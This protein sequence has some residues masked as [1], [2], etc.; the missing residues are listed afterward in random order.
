MKKCLTIDDDKE[1]LT[2]FLLND[3]KT[4]KNFPGIPMNK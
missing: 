3:W 2:D 4:N 1:E